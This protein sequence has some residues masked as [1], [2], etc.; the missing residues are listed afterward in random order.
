MVVRLTRGNSSAT[1]LI[2]SIVNKIEDFGLPVEPIRLSAI[3]LFIMH[4]SATFLE[5]MPPLSNLSYSN[6]S[7]AINKAQIIVD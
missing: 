4:I 2:I 3:P 1:A 5:F 6:Y 7:W